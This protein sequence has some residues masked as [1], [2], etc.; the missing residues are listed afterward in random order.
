MFDTRLRIDAEGPAGIPTVNNY[1]FLMTGAAYTMEKMAPF[2]G[3]PVVPVTNRNGSVVV[4]LGGPAVRQVSNDND[5]F[6]RAGDDIFV[7]PPG[8]TWSRIFVSVLTANNDE[9]RRRRGLLMPVVQKTALEYYRDVFTRTYAESRFATRPHG[10]FD[11]AAEFLR[12]SKAN[13]LRCLLGLDVTDEHLRLATEI[14]HLVDGVILP[15]IAA[16]PVNLSWTPYGRW[17]RRIARAYDTLAELIEQRRREPDRPDALSIVCNTS[18]EHGDYLST[19][20]VVGELAGFFAAGFETTA[21]TMTLGLVTMIAEARGRDLTSQDVV[22]ACVN[23]S[24]R[25]LPS[26]PVSLPRRVRR[27]VDIEG[28]CVPAGALLFLSSVVEHH[29]PAVYADPYAYRPERWLGGT[30]PKP[31]EFMPFGIGARRCLGAAFADLQAR[32]TLGLI[33]ARGLPVLRTGVIDYGMR[34]GIVGGTR[35]PVPISYAD[36]EGPQ[37]ITGTVTRLWHPS[38]I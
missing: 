13:M 28:V 14:V 9:H 33:A 2:H 25:L 30:T 37:R 20:E 22:D 8:H 3:Q 16:L 11:A 23:E 34:S 21:M 5:V 36:A 26:A 32:T 12:I 4:A 6:H 7:M 18:D 15:H 10:D 35:K 27:D 24:M 29:N 17:L 1:R 38:P 31:W 19:E